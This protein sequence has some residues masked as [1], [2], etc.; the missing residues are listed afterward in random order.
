ML[1]SA[2]AGVSARPGFRWQLFTAAVQFERDALRV[3][4]GSR[5]R[6]K[7]PPCVWLASVLIPLAPDLSLVIESTALSLDKSLS[8]VWD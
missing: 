2:R 1:R 5:H 6:T 7:A 4:R 3:N 8:F